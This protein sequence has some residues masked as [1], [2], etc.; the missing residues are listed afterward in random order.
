MPCSNLEHIILLTVH[1]VR[2][3]NR[4]SRSCFV[5][6]DRFVCVGQTTTINSREQHGFKFNKSAGRS[7]EFAAC[8]KGKADN[9]NNCTDVMIV[10]FFLL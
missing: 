7:S 5:T 4:F 9:F 1:F 10:D 6:R 8:V 2:F 3:V